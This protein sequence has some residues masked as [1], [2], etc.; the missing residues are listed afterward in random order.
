MSDLSLE[1]RIATRPLDLSLRFD[2]RN[3]LDEEYETVLSHPMPRMNFG[4]YI[5]ITP[6]FRNAAAGRY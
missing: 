4:F 3:L 2:I 5:G 6:K 1:R